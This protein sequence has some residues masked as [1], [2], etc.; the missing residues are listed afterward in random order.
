[1]RERIDANPLRAF[2]S[3]DEG[4][5]AVMA[6]APTMLERLEEDDA[7]H[8]A[9]VR[10]AAR[11]G[12]GRLRRSTAPW[13]AAS[14]TTRAPSSPSSPSGW[15]PSRRSAAAGA[16][17]AWSSSSA[18]RPRRRPAG[19]RGRADPAGAGR[20]APRR[21]RSD[22][23]VVAEDGQRDRALALVTELRRA[24]LRADLDLAGRERQ[25]A[26]EAGR[27]ARAPAAR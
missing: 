10:R 21:R 13:S 3:K 20:A 14:T 17:T 12:W 16:T 11:P 9:E 27:P 26:D 18:A 5:R 6:G 8:F 2:D 23:F 25:G 1:M 22:V 24:G 15:A 7:E 19:R 4:T